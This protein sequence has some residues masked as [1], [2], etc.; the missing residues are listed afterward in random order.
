M[1]HRAALA[2]S[3]AIGGLVLVVASL[4]LIAAGR[5]LPAYPAWF[6]LA[7]YAV[8]LL[9]LGGLIFLSGLPIYYVIRAIQKARGINVDL[10]YK[11]IPPE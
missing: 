5:P 8:P 11:E 3:L 9:L 2:W 7:A 10:A 4:A 1:R 6:A